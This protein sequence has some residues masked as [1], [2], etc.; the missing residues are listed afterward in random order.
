MRSTASVRSYDV[1][2]CVLTG[3]HPL[4]GPPPAG[5]TQGRLEAVCSLLN[6]QLRLLPA[7]RRRTLQAQWFWILPPEQLLEQQQQQ[8]LEGAGPPDASAQHADAGGGTTSTISQA[9]EAAQLGAAR[10]AAS[11]GAAYIAAPCFLGAVAGYAFKLGGQG[12]G[13][14]A[15]RPP[16][17][18]SL[19]THDSVRMSGSGPGG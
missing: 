16:E 3:R 9:G 2:G 6:T 11:S 15:D 12:V 18:A 5:A 17:T 1:A 7:F 8:Q 10:A 13:Y 14:Y 4:P 19:L